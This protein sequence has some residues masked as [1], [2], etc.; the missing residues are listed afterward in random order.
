VL[1]FRTLALVTLSQV[2]AAWHA[3]DLVQS[4]NPQALLE[5]IKSAVNTGGAPSISAW[6]PMEDNQPGLG[7]L[8]DV[9]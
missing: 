9:P 2:T 4:G 7:K 8:K 3:C 6:G 1:V 5:T